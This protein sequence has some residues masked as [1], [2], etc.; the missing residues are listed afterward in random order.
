MNVTIDN[1]ST[2][3]AFEA[4]SVMKAAFNYVHQGWTDETSSQFIRES[5]SATLPLVA[6]ID[7][8]IVGILVAEKKVNDLVVDAIGVLPSHMGKGVAKKLWKAAEA[9]AQKK[10]LENIKM[11]ADPKSPAYQWYKRM[12]FKDTGW[13][14]IMKT[15]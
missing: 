8:Q 1:M 12:G 14:E 13:V 6:R 3:N 2:D 9:F 4:A 15:V 5:L 10:R 7:G 11:I